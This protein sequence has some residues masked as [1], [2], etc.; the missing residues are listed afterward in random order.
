MASKF[1]GGNVGQK[2]PKDMTVGS[3]TG[4]VAVE[5]QIDLAKV[6]DKLQVVQ[7]LEGILNYV[8]TT[9]SNPIS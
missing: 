1:I 4:S 3:S 2:M 6:T 9:A 7:V 5:V 8:K